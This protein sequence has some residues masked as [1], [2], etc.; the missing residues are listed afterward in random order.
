MRNLSKLKV[1]ALCLFLIGALGAGFAADVNGR[2]KGSVTHP[3]G[4]VLA[5]VKVSAAN[6]ATG[7]KF[8]TTTGPDG[9]YLFPQLPIG[10]YTVAVSASGFKSFTAK[11]IV[12]NIDQEYVEPIKLSVGSTAEIV[13]VAAAPVQVDTTDM[14]L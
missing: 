1:L 14:Q 11:G 8:D 3:Q 10:T 4:A 5:G 2:I 13:E 7:V 9:G 12:L 6:E